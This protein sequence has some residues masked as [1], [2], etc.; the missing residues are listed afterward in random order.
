[1]DFLKTKDYQN[2]DNLTKNDL[3]NVI[4]DGLTWQVFYTLTFGG[5]FLIGFALLLG[6]NPFQ[7]GLISSLPFFAS[8]VQII[9]SYFI[10]RSGKRR[11]MALWTALLS[12]MLWI[13]IILIPLLILPPA[14]SIWLI[15]I[16]FALSSIFNSLSGVAWMSWMSIRVPK[17]IMGKFFSKRTVYMSL[18]G[19]VVGLLGGFFI[20]YW[21]FGHTD[22][23]GGFLIL[24]SIGTLFSIFSVFYLSRVKDFPTEGENV[25]LKSF[26]KLVKNPFKDSDFRKFV[27]FGMVWGF[28]LGLAGPFILV[29]Q[30][31]TLKLDYIMVVAL[32]TLFVVS[33]VV[34]LGKWGEIVDKYGAKPIIVICAFI[35]SLYPLFFLFITKSNSMLL[36]PINIIGGIAWGGL[37]F[38]FAQ[39]LLRTVPQTNRSIYFSAFAGSNGIAFA[40]AP[41]IGGFLASVFTN[42]S[43]SFLFFTFSGLHFLFIM[44][45]LLR[46]WSTSLVKNINEPASRPTD[47]VLSNL[48]ENRLMG[49]FVNFYSITR[50][51]FEI[52]AIPFAFSRNIARRG[53]KMVG[54]GIMKIGSGSAKSFVEMEKLI[55]MSIT[56]LSKI[57]YKGTVKIVPRLTILNKRVKN[58]ENK[59]SNVDDKNAVKEI[60]TDIKKV[61][62]ETSLIIQKL[63]S[64]PH[65]TKIPESYLKKVLRLVSRSRK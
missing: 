29:Y 65:N 19:V 31:D 15:I 8:V 61:E 7:I 46:L 23:L 59:M 39:I 9:G 21:K 33:G 12:R 60:Q 26:I 45:G 35:V 34:T 17:P 22:P 18:V 30:I 16:V 44:S 48:K 62:T 40:I 4:L 38:A 50:F 49:V 57:G 43:Y 3:N 24:F 55:G 13:L 52:V 53:G 28:A 51:S 58:L 6:A 1:M 37:D 27:K 25:N 54:K 36:I 20:D 56:E 14:K 10:E 47:E 11:F 32:S 2:V 42:L 64:T 63:E 41:I 5:V